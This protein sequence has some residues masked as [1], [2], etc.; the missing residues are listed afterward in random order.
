MGALLAAYATP[1]IGWRGLFAVGLLPAFL[2]LYIRA[3]VPESPYWL[4]RMGRFEE[5]RQSVGWALQMDPK[6][7]TLP[8]VAPAVE[9]T[10][11]LELFKYPRSIFAGALTGLSQTGGVGLGLWRVTLLVMVLQITAPVAS[12]LVVWL[13]I[14]A[15][16]GRFFCSWISDAWGRRT[17]GVFSC[18]TAALTMALAGYLH[19]VFIAGVSL[20]D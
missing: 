7:I 12:G 1:Y 11:W 18:L 4:M 2:T 10:R 13:S 3:W 9:H 6:D 17:G 8:A 19:N 15:I 16:V 20:L 5:A 14:S